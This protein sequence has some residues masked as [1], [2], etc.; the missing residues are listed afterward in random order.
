MKYHNKIQKNGKVYRKSIF[1]FIG[2]IGL[3][4][5]LQVGLSNSLSTAGEKLMTL[6]YDSLNLQ[7]E[8]EVLSNEIAK[9]QSLINIEKLAL[10][11]GFTKIE[12]KLSIA[13]P[14]PVAL[15]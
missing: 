11:K 14:I 10:E 6:Q 15:K 8:N 13:A 1:L 9:R 2:I 12:N 4:M 5:V 7:K 3:L